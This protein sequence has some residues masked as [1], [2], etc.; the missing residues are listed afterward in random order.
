MRVLIADD[1]LQVRSALRLVLQQDPRVREIDEVE[2]L[3]ALLQHVQ[4]SPAHLVLLDWE[5]P[6]GGGS[7]AVDRMRALRPR[8]SVI[9]LS[10]RPEAREAALRNGADAFVSKGD[11]PER[12]LEAVDALHRQR[13][14]AQ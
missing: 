6:D 9:A 7:V 13:H 10:G 5:L 14:L 1:Q 12:L 11:P 3:E 8:L 2:N 4:R